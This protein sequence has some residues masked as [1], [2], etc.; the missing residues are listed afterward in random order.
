MCGT[1]CVLDAPMGAAVRSEP[2]ARSDET[3]TRQGA[4]DPTPREIT[5][6]VLWEA[7]RR[8]PAP[9]RVLDHRRS[10]A[11]GR[12][13]STANLPL[14]D[15]HCS[16]LHATLRA[17][18]GGATVEDHSSNGTF[19]EGARVEGR[20]FARDG[21]VVRVGDS[22]LLVR[23]RPTAP[24]EDVEIEG[25]DGASP[26]M[27]ALRRGIAAVAPTPA[28][29]L[30]LGE[31]GTGKE[32][33]AR[34]LHRLADRRGAFVAVN[35]AAIPEG[36]AE[37]QL[38]GHVRG[39]FTDARSDHPGFFRAADG[40][41]LLLD[42]IGDLS[43]ALQAK[44][45]R[46]LEERAVIPVGGTK[47]VP[48][49]VRLVAATHRDLHADVDAGRFRGDLYARIAEYTLRTAPLRERREDILPLLER[50]LGPE[51]PPLGPELVAALLLCPYRFNVRELFAIARQLTIDGRG[52]PR[53][54]VEH[55]GGRLSDG[56]RG[57]S[58]GGV[59]AGTSPELAAPAQ[60]GA[61]SP[62]IALPPSPAAIAGPPSGELE[63]G[64]ATETMEREPP[65]S[66]ERLEALLGEHRGNVSEIARVLGRS[67]RQVH[68][69]LESFGLDLERFR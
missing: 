10:I 48:I 51:A 49:D 32:S 33:T 67:R 19:L 63:L 13:V 18:E 59:P 2:V 64:D 62:A 56:G 47:E 9:P 46:V 30:V 8:P 29:V 31:T 11:V 22:F 12:T 4:A 41:T 35:C 26:G 14:A 17:A 42:E 60:P 66:R 57:S 1:P 53:L 40:G 25:L 20:A 69:Y 52:A 68:R 28:R 7:G 21:D 15:P 24:V 3:L 39:A 44:L 27:V 36:L 65:P 43:P 54:E 16:R 58:P 6:H 5:I 55:A 38:F 61:T 45:L 34:A 23:L 50:A 37:S